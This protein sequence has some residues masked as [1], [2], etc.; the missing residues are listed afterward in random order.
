MEYVFSSIYG[1]QEDKNG[2]FNFEKFSKRGEDAI[3]ELD[4]ERL[5]NFANGSLPEWGDCVKN[6][7]EYDKVRISYFLT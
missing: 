1:S 5:L 7:L 4:L 2:L 6:W 3:P